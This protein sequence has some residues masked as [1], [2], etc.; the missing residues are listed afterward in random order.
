M[1]K[2]TVAQLQQDHRIEYV[3]ADVTIAWARL[4]EAKTHLASAAKLAR[5]DPALAYVALY[6]AARKSIVAHM[7]ANGYRPVNRAGTHRAVA[8]YAE[9]TL[10]KGPAAPHVMAYDRMRQ[11]RNRSEYD[12]KPITAQ[13]LT[14]DL[15]HAREIVAA[16]EAALPPRP[17]RPR[18][19]GGK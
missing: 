10:A 8:Q 15:A 3:S 5:S 11:I 17:P 2:P 14:T 4:D 18:L 16:I 13:V 7:Q 6:D 1:P 19:A 12:H 9:A